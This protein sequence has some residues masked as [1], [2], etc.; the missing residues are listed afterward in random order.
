[1]PVVVVVVMMVVMVF[2]LMLVF[3]SKRRGRRIR[4]GGTQAL[5]LLLSLLENPLV[6]KRAQPTQQL[7]IHL[8][9]AFF[10]PV[11]CA[12]LFALLAGLWR[13]VFFL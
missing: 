3:L 5:P 12:L 8:S 4:M 2:R 11:E 13:S 6:G 9:S 1:M 10:L 7:P